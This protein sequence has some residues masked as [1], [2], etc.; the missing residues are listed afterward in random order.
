MRR[1]SDDPNELVLE[2]VIGCDKARNSGTIKAIASE[3][4]EAT[5][6]GYDTVRILPDGPTIEV[7]K[8][9]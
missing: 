9:A 8:G 2:R 1:D 3:Y 5:E 4:E 7:L 6:T